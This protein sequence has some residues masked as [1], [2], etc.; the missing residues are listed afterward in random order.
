MLLL[1]GL[2]GGSYLLWHWNPNMDSIPG[3]KNVGK[4]REGKGRGAGGA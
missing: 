3:K 4:G 1:L 2:G